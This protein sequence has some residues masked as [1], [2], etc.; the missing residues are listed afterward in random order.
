MRVQAAD[1]ARQHI[2]R[3]YEA[4]S[5]IV[6]LGCVA[7][8]YVHAAVRLECHV[9]LQH[10]WSYTFTMLQSGYVP[11]K[12][13]RDLPASVGAGSM[14]LMSL[15]GRCTGAAG[16]D[17]DVGGER[18]RCLPGQHAAAASAQPLQAICNNV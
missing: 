2:P 11:N 8:Q 3:R 18:G 10:G 5:V 9:Q 13:L 16:A 6:T 15:A 7:L 14:T 17:L 1:P 4:E 12:A